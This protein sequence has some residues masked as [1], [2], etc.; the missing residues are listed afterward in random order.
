METSKV[1]AG[2]RTQRKSRVVKRES[3][4]K[5]AVR[6]RQLQRHHLGQSSAH[7]S[8]GDGLTPSSTAN[9]LATVGGVTRISSNPASTGQRRHPGPY[10]EA[11]EGI[12]TPFTVPSQHGQLSRSVPVDPLNQGEHRQFP[13]QFQSPGYDNT[14]TNPS[15]LP[16]N[17]LLAFADKPLSLCNPEPVFHQ[18]HSDTDGLQGVGLTTFPPQQEPPGT[19]LGGT[20]SQRLSQQQPIPKTY[21]NATTDYMCRPTLGGDS[22][23]GEIYGYRSSH[24]PRHGS[25]STLN[26]PDT[27]GSSTSY[28]TQSGEVSSLISG[29]QDP[30]ISSSILP[31]NV[32]LQPI[33]QTSGSYSNQTFT[34]QPQYTTAPILGSFEETTDFGYQNLGLLPNGQFTPPFALIDFSLMG[35]GDSYPETGGPTLP[36]VKDLIA[37]TSR[38]EELDQHGLDLPIQTQDGM[39]AEAFATRSNYTAQTMED[40]NSSNFGEAFAS[41]EAMSEDQVSDEGDSNC[42]ACAKVR[43]NSKK[44]IHDLPCVRWKLTRITLY[45]DGGLNLTRRWSGLELKDVPAI[46]RNAP[47]RFIEVQQGLC[48]VPLKFEVVEFEPQPGDATARFWTGS[49]HKTVTSVD[50]YIREHAVMTF[51]EHIHQRNDNFNRIRGWN[52]PLDLIQRTQKM[53]VKHYLDLCN[54][55]GPLQ[56]P[57]GDAREQERVLLENVFALWM[58]IQLTTGSFWISG[59]ET[60][61]MEPEKQDMSYPLFNKVSAPRMIVAQFDNVNY[62]LLVHYREKVLKSLEDVIITSNS[63]RWLTVYVILF[64]FLR[65]ASDVSNDRYRHARDNYGDKIRYSIPHFV[66]ELHNGCNNMLMHWHYFNS[67]DW[68]DESDPWERHRYHLSHLKPEQLALIQETRTCGE[69]QNHLRVWKVHKDENGLAVSTNNPSR[70]QGPYSGRQI[71]YD[72][73][74]EYYWIA[75]LFEHKWQAH[76][77]Y[78]REPVPPS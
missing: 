10:Y 23:Q 37:E 73:D 35:G 48:S 41:E 11:A 59:T 65:Q 17:D 39:P 18:S 12:R 74:H 44:L 29:F 51:M 52:E 56:V 70:V 1:P 27:A 14:S 36:A 32:N 66:E 2:V 30:T 54:S 28:Y 63:T 9:N 64:I 69:V 43:R 40:G 53:A 68:P 7:Q 75:Q 16:S 38:V 77:T 60:L 22:G 45:R 26:F 78:Q 55:T 25:V 15:A 61:G 5:G 13:S 76:P 24:G 3:A 49:I 8:G 50:N 20:H 67:Q 19:Q 31:H 58:A 72:W 46:H 42:L 47:S 21:Q 57:R 33:D 62:K 71:A 6:S 4:V 34:P